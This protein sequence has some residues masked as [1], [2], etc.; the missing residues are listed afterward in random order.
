MKRVLVY[1][2]S[3]NWGGV[4]AIVMAIIERL[5]KCCHFD[6][7]HSNNSSSYETKYESENI[8][9]VHLPTWGSDRQGFTY[10]LK[11][12]LQTN[13][14]DY[15]WINACIMSNAT[16]VSV[17]KKYSNAKIITHSHGSSFEEKNVIKRWILLGLHYWNRR[18]YHKLVDIPCCCSFKSA[19]WYYGKRYTKRKDVYFIKN[20][21]DYEKYRFNPLMRKEYR[22]LLNIDEDTLV[23][24]H[25]GRLTH[26]K[27][28]TKLLDIL[29]ALS[30]IGRKAMLLIAGDGE[31]H[32]ELMSYAGKLGISGYVRFLGMRKDVNSLMQAAD[33]FL[34]PSFHE[35]F[36][37]TIVEAQTAGLPCLVSA[38]LSREVDI[39]KSVKF[40]PIEL[41][42][43]MWCKEIEQ[44]D[45]ER[46]EHISELVKQSGYD[47]EDVVN[48]LK[49]RLML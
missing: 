32:E 3:N 47:I 36:P 14:Y 41:D 12:L 35:G 42:A 37:V 40:I 49:N 39:T 23:L 38:N 8:Q 30:M 9:F 20:G 31:L 46:R 25:A 22:K 13:D 5:G 18:K 44:F 4:E 43:E 10:S 16:I 34:L 26:V 27:N 11:N 48:N 24:F 7:I 33:V 19:D 2:L 15:V 6:I 17:V 45:S 28:Q 29:K 21:V 1:G